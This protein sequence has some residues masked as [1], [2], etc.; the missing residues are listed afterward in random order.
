M[1]VPARLA[2]RPCWRWTSDTPTVSATDNTHSARQILGRST[3]SWNAADT[4]RSRQFRTRAALVCSVR[5]LDV[6][7]ME[8]TCT[9]AADG[10][11]RDLGHDKRRERRGHHRGDRR[12]TGADVGS[13]RRTAACVFRF[14]G[15]CAEGARRHVQRG[16]AHPARPCRR[17]HREAARHARRARPRRASAVQSRAGAGPRPD[18]PRQHAEPVLARDRPGSPAARTGG[19]AARSTRDGSTARHRA[20][21]DSPGPSTGGHDRTACTTAYGRRGHAARARPSNGCHTFPI[22]AFTFAWSAVTDIDRGARQGHRTLP[23]ADLSRARSTPTSAAAAQLA[24]HCRGSDGGPRAA[25]SGGI[26]TTE[27]GA[28]RLQASG[29]PA[30]PARHADSV[31]RSSA[32][33]DALATGGLPDVRP[34]D[35]S[36]RRVRRRRCDPTPRSRVRGS[37]LPGLR[38]L[39]ARASSLTRLSARDSGKPLRA[40]VR[41]SSLIPDP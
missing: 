23:P 41:R 6:E 19:T 24:G 14:C 12:A 5:G 38:A 4:P 18:N 9:G 29:Q 28:D 27:A 16:R 11:P 17:A 33:G 15:R 36:Q 10:H 32:H 25:G 26:R 31:D 2:W 30:F 20:C 3:V 35:P 8:S 39:G 22:V 1:E 21:H 37:W 13:C 40:S 7:R 34:R